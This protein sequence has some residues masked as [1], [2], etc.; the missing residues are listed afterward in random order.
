MSDLLRLIGFILFVIGIVLYAEPFHDIG[1]VHTTLE[2]DMRLT[3]GLSWDSLTMTDDEPDFPRITP[4]E[5]G[6]S[7]ASTMDWKPITPATPPPPPSPRTPVDE[8][9]PLRIPPK[10]TR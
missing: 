10:E 5:T 2:E 6:G 1:R 3:P 4:K 8:V 9:N 7:K